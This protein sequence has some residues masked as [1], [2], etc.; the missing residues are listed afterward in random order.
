MCKHSAGKRKIAVEHASTEGRGGV[1]GLYEREHAKQQQRISK[2]KVFGTRAEK[3]K[4]P[5]ISDGR[6][7]MSMPSRAT[8]AL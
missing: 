1:E 6:K 7:R 4:S 3:D 2:H 8:E 5:R